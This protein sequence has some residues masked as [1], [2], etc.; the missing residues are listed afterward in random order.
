MPK[1]LVDHYEKKFENA[2]SYIFGS[3]LIVDDIQTARKVGIGR[4]RMTA[5]DGTLI[6][7]SGAMIGGHRKKTIGV[8]EQ[9]DIDADISSSE[10]DLT[11]LQEAMIW[12]VKI[13]W[14]R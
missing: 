14:K 6:E 3:T 4:I 2:F 8:F 13:F 11:Q 10:K 9:K 7:P 5:L 1:I 12:D